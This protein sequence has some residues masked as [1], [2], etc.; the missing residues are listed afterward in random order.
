MLKRMKIECLQDL[1]D[2]RRFRRSVVVPAW[3]VWK[4]PKPAAFMMN[5]SGEILLR[6]FNKGMY[7]YEPKRKVPKGETSE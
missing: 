4:D 6:M 2:I 7:L 3:S 5:L 1:Y